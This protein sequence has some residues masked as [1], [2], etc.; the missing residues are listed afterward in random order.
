MLLKRLIIKVLS[1]IYYFKYSLNYD[2][3]YYETEQGKKFE[4]YDLD[5]KAGLT[6]L[7]ELKNQFKFLIHLFFFQ[8][9]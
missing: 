7:N 9:L 6:K 4:K 2:E 3:K 8:Y 1:I 5:R